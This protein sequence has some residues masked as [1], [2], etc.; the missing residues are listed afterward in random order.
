MISD[1]LHKMLSHLIGSVVERRRRRRGVTSHKSF[2]SFD[3]FSP[4]PYF[5]NTKHSWEGIQKNPD[6]RMLI[7]WFETCS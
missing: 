7:I 3:N 2:A 5:D 1:F 6:S 4:T